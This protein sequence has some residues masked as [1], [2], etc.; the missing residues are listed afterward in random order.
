MGSVT[1][2]LPFES[3]VE[4][5]VERRSLQPTLWQERERKKGLH[6][7]Q[8][9]AELGLSPVGGWRGLPA[10]WMWIS[11]WYSRLISMCVHHSRIE[12][13]KWLHQCSWAHPSQ[14]VRGRPS[15]EGGL[16]W[17]RVSGPGVLK[18]G[19]RCFFNCICSR[20]VFCSSFSLE[21]GCCNTKYFIC[22]T[23]NRSG[24]QHPHNHPSEVFL[25]MFLQWFF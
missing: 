6:N 20:A 11:P 18:V 1:V 8:A 4:A 5:N 3:S 7:K 14:N 23:Y 9:A 2:W 22:Q 24:M 12:V 16:V 10:T 19:R 25:K 21:V 15:R 17:G 13:V